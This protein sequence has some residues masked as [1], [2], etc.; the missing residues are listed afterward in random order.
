MTMLSL[1][2][3]TEHSV[4]CSLSVLVCLRTVNIT[5]MSQQLSSLYYLL[6]T[7]TMMY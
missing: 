6:Y 4:H 7:T 2:A 5:S 1:D 3:V